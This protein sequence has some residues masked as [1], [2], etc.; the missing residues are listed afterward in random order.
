MIRSALA[1]PAQLYRATGLIAPAYVTIVLMAAGV[2]TARLLQSSEIP[3]LAAIELILLGLP[4]TLALG[5]APISRLDWPASV[6]FVALTVAGNLALLWWLERFIRRFL[7]GTLRRRPDDPGELQAQ[8]S[9]N[10]E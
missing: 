2:A 5:V 10:R 6:A 1:S 9:P 8:N 7:T 4:W 3:G